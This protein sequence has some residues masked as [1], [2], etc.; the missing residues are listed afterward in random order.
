MVFRQNEI[1]MINDNVLVYLI[2]V[3]YRVDITIYNL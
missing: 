1:L 3:F 2:T